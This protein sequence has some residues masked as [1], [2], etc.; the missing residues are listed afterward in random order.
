MGKTDTEQYKSRLRDFIEI[1]GISVNDNK[2]PPVLRCPNPSHADEHPSAVIYH[3]SNKV[4]CPV[5]GE[6]WDIFEVAGLLDG[7]STFPDKLKSV[8]STLGMS[9]IKPAGAQKKATVKNTTGKKAT[10]KKPKKQPPKIVPLE[11]KDA[12]DLLWPQRES[13]TESIMKFNQL[14]G[15]VRFIKVWPYYDSDGLIDLFDIR[16][17]N[18]L[19]KKAV[20]SYVWN[21]KYFVM[22]GVPVLLFNRHLIAQNPDTPILI[23]E[24]AKAAEAA[25]AIPGFVPVTWN[26]GGKKC[27]QVDWSPL[28]DRVVYIYPDDD[29][30]VYGEK[31]KRAGEL[32]SPHEQ[33]GMATALDIKKKLPQAK[34]LQPIES[35]RKVKA[36]GADIV[37]VMQVP[38][39]TPEVVA[40][41]ILNGPEFQPP[42]PTPDPA[43]S[44]SPIDTPRET[45]EISTFP[46]RILGVAD[47][48][49]AYFLD[50]HERLS[51][52]A[53]KSLT[54][55]MLMTLAP[56]PWW[57][58]EYASGGKMGKDEWAQATD[59]VIQL[60]GSIDFDPD[61]I[62]GR[63]AWRE[64]DG[65]VCY[66]DGVN[67]IGDAG[68]NRLYL[69]MTRKDIG[70]GGHQG[71]QGAAHA[72]EARTA[73][74][75]DV[76]GELSFD[77]RADMIRCLAWS[78]LA[79]F[80]GALP[81]RPAGLLTGRSE[82]GKSTIVDLIIKPLASPMVVSGGESTEAGVRQ[83]VNIDSMAV[84]VEE[85]ETDT[86]KKKQR[87]DDILS[88]MRQSTSDE[89]PKAVKGTIDGKGMRF[90]LRSM[91]L[92]VAINPEVE[93]IADDNRMFRVNL[94]GKG[95][96]PE[97]WQDLSKKLEGLITPELC[98]GIR[99][100]TWSKLQD[101]F[102]MSDRMA[103]TIQR[104]THKSSRYAKAE[105]LLFAAY[106]VVWKGMGAEDLS[107]DNLQE[108]F[109]QIYKW[110]PV[111]ESRKEEEELLDEILDS[112]IRDGKDSLTIRQVL[113]RCKGHDKNDYWSEVIERYGMRLTQDGDLA[114]AKNYPEIMRMTGRGKGYQMTL[115]RHRLYL[116]D[117]NISIGGAVR[118][119]VLIKREIIAGDEPDF[120]DAPDKKG[121]EPF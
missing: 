33:P 82:S 19:G 81:W 119:A 39:M 100:L 107:D 109:E 91:F 69:R 40:K 90:T 4:Y 14:D 38:L 17:E 102:A 54:Q 25:E 55:N 80:A 84:V 96:T 89:T 23:V 113:L 56:L 7:L 24:G 60:A 42:A 78:T 1:R 57:Q 110:Q 72:T 41:Y 29:Q 76:I 36:D 61:R 51:S 105:S 53:L 103:S 48:G 31:H 21:G 50:R 22:K 6:S 104:V 77:T 3:D 9:D 73:A 30:K 32:L 115:K 86:P 79:P 62:R 71:E 37:E 46:F 95:H 44:P 116:R 2:K 70:L 94:E 117:H 99:A 87:R 75:L 85:A 98:S 8:Q 28:R 58:T 49:K 93:S 18:E 64:R 66:H 111:E 43:P 106:Q 20:I 26:G 74:I 59:M 108:F 88:L 97:Q 35:A 52:A 45:P 27:K 92:F 121:D 112:I 11:R 68:D 114:I 67:T 65:R 118:N 47:D 5:C 10:D 16:Y 15:D 13:L 83:A 12:I 34:I 63:G 120:L 101:I